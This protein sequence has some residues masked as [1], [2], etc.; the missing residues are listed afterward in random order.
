M[1]LAIGRRQLVKAGAFGAA[2]LSTSGLLLRPGRAA[3]TT[4]YG[5][6]WGGPYIEAMNTIAARQDAVSV[7]WE[8][9]ASG[10]AAILAKIKAT[11]PDTPYDFI[12]ADDATITSMINEGWLETIDPALVPN[13]ASVPEGYML[14]DADGNVKNIPRS[15]SGFYFGY[16]SD[17]A[18]IAIESIDDLLR[19]E[20][21]GQI[22]WP[23]PIQM[24][25]VHLVALARHAGGSE[26]DIEPGWAFIKELAASGNIGRI[27]QTE[28]DAINSLTSGETSVSFWHL[29]VWM[30]VARN[31]PVVQITKRDG[32]TTFLVTTGYAVLA[33]RPAIPET[34]AFLNHAIAPENVATYSDVVGEAP[35]STAVPVDESMAHM[36]FTAEEAAKYTTIPDWGYIAA[37]RDAWVRRWEEEVAPLL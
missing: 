4:L 17:I 14:R 19:P 35:A 30:N 12:A 6:E 3:D 31:V 33:G 23:H 5:V 13:L 10:A 11:W 1:T 37:Q 18:P 28:T 32:F 16:R 29:A 20:L 26:R 8:L 22:C 7:Q 25:G 24:S 21:A 27:A 36:M 15:L 34:L 9:H 2:F